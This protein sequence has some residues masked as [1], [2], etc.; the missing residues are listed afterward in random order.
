M[1]CL[2]LRP[3]Y[4]GSKRQST[5]RHVVLALLNKQLQHQCEF[6]TFAILNVYF[7]MPF[8]PCFIEQTECG[9]STATAEKLL[10]DFE[11]GSSILL[12]DPFARFYRISL[13]TKLAQ[14]Y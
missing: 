2:A 10:L 14:T 9:L 6:V 5:R 7:P 4:N 8:T 13:L 1:W 12:L 3:L 11:L